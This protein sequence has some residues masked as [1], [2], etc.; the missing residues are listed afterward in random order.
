MSNGIFLSLEA[1]HHPTTHKQQQQQLTNG[2]LVPYCP[3]SPAEH[4]IQFPKLRWHNNSWLSLTQPTPIQ[5]IIIIII[6]TKALAAESRQIGSRRV[7]M[8]NFLV[9]NRQGRVAVAEISIST[10]DSGSVHHVVQISIKMM[11]VFT[12]QETL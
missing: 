4:L 5:H 2:P 7:M 10:P 9:L 12:Y 3:P 11:R 6:T 8:I 1:F